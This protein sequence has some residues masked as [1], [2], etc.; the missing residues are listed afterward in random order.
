M[1]HRL[2]IAVLATAGIG[3]TP[4][5]PAMPTWQQ[6][7][8]V[9]H[10][11]RQGV[12]GLGEDR[13][14]QVVRAAFGEWVTFDCAQVSVKFLGRTDTA[15]DAMAADGVSVVGWISEAFSERT[16]G[17]PSVVGLT[18]VRFSSGRVTE[19]DMSLNAQHW[20]WTA[21]SSLPRVNLRTI[22]RHEAGHYLGM[23][24]SDE[25]DATMYPTYGG[26]VTLFTPDDR[27]GI[28]TLYPVDV[29][30]ASPPIAVPPD[31]GPGEPTSASASLVGSGCSATSGA[32]G[33]SAADALLLILTLSMLRRG[34][35]CGGSR[36]RWR[37][38]TRR[39]HGASLG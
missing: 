23:G 7:A 16:G 18:V 14:E 34:R 6:G 9:V 30:E 2:A 19:A 8:A 17:D 28:C 38:I 36:S 32:T 31:G 15:P 24:H 37:S 11:E 1:I 25:P 4:I 3:W 5:D 21:A 26:G 20:G 10:M 39:I 33:P 13:S 27:E 22:L 12:P 29:G 35:T